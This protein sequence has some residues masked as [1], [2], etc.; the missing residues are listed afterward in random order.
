V[1][2]ACL[3]KCLGRKGIVDA[4]DFLKTKDVRGFF[5]QQPFNKIDPQ[6]N[7]IDVPGRL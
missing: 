3:V 5:S 7:G 1:L 4:F 2:I 6:A